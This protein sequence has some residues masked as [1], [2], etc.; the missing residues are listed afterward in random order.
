MVPTTVDL[1]WIFVLVGEITFLTCEKGKGDDCNF[2][3]H[4]SR[5][6]K[7]A[8]TDLSPIQIFFV[9]SCEDP[10][11]KA[12]GY[13][14]LRKL[15]DRWMVQMGSLGTFDPINGCNRKDDAKAKSYGSG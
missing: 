5:C 14:L 12:D 3:E 6:H 4:W 9:D 15:E 1:Q 8:L 2:C 7:E 10:G 13:P 11:S